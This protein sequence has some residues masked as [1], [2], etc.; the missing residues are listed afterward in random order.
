MFFIRWLYRAYSNVDAVDPG[1]R[2]YAHG[3][4]IG[5]W[6]VPI[7]TLWRPKQIV[8]DVWWAGTPEGRPA[9]AWPGLLLATWWIAFWI[10]NIL[11][12]VASRTGT[13]DDPTTQELR[14]GTLA[15]VAS[16]AFDCVAAASRDSRGTCGDPADGG[17]GRRFAR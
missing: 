9:D 5:G 10:S 3:W 7:L 8:N 11:G 12:Q 2:R 4:A 1:A 14:D 15:Y 16:D 6:F 13:G 17:Q